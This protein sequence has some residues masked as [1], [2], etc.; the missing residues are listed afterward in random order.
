MAKP[1]RYYVIEFGHSQGWFAIDGHFDF[2]IAHGIKRDWQ[3]R[4]KED[5]RKETYRV[6]KYI[7]ETP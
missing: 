6:K 2:R 1:Q 7:P 3:K 5:C 4:A